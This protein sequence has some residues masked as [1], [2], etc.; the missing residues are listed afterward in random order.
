MTGY[1]VFKEIPMSDINKIQA[2]L[3]KRDT[4]L[5]Q[6]TPDGQIDMA[7]GTWGHLRLERHMARSLHK[8][9]GVII[10]NWDR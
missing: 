1:L 7:F 9:L 10:S 3:T 8:A 6:E 5:V 4:L 2:E